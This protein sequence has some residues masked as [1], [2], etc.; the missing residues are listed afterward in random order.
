MTDKQEQFNEWVAKKKM[1]PAGPP[2]PLWLIAVALVL[3]VTL[4]VIL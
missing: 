4:Y 3:M 1:H 2:M